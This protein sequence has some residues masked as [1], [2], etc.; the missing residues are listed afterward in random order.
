MKTSVRV[1]PQAPQSK[2][3][4]SEDA[5]DHDLLLN[6]LQPYRG[7][8]LIALALMLAQSVT[9]LASPWIAGRFSTAVLN[10]QAVSQLL[11]DWFVLI[12]VQSLLSYGAS[13]RLQKISV[14]LI[15]DASTR[16][17][18]HLQG[19]PLGWHQD[20]RRGDILSLVTQDVSRLGYFVTETLTPLLPL[21][22][23]CA[24]ALLMMLRIE[25]WVGLAAAVLMP[26]LFIALRLV[27][28]RLRPLGHE[29]VQAYAT[30]SAIAEQ[31]L[32]ML[33]VVKAFAGE[34]AESDRFDAQTRTL[35]DLELTQT[36]S[37]AIVGPAVRVISAA[38]VLLLLWIANREIAQGTMSAGGLVSLLL[39]GLLL[40]QPLSA[41]A[42]VYG[43][44]QSARGAMQRLTG[45]F[46]EAREPDDGEYEPVSARGAIVFEKVEFGYPGRAP[47][48]RGLDL[49]VGAGE[50]VAITGINGAGKSTLAYLLL[51]FADP[52][53]G[54]ILFDG[55]D[56]HEFTLR[57]LRGHI[58][59]VSQNVLLF[60]ASVRDNI[61]YG[62][63]SA[64]QEQ[65]EQAARAARAHDFVVSLPHSYGTL[66]GDQGIRLS[67]GQKQRI[68]LAR[69]LLKNPA[70]LILDE[71]T[72]MFD[73]AGEREFIE[74]CHEL[75]SQ[76]TVLL[77]TH[78]PA[79]LALA[80]RVLCMQHGRLMD[81]TKPV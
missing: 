63:V 49:S 62:R 25:P 9:A 41:L 24:G 40:T 76:R 66:V 2:T 31:N 10:H 38:G 68:A 44:S 43:Q 65:I 72:A 53:A 35:R 21:M 52:E 60:N 74:E 78:R 75:L 48:L 57:N 58:G 1:E 30:R 69:A 39:Y 70:V 47:V 36:R 4:R 64:T 73:P 77:I 5:G 32:V 59:L 50:T 13:V 19:L 67:G 37:H 51:R 22:L 29:V 79:S 33:P 16:L 3:S 42:S 23:T 61:A 11:L 12:A 54:R 17:F 71:A 80:D 8:L 15:A 81:V 26:A 45:V 28:R 6:L 56:L 7:A 14:E 20:R 27:G 46:R 55:H 18:D 34:D